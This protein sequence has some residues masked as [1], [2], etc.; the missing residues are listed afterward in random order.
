M[1]TSAPSDVKPAAKTDKTPTSGRRR[2]GV[3]GA[4]IGVAAAGVAA[5]IAVE[6]LVVRRTRKSDTDPYADE[7]FGRLP[8]DETTSV[9]TAD[10]VELHVEIVEPVDGVAV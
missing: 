6:R 3:I 1:S 5:G 10:G 2:A 9:A 7:P 4:V 8:Y